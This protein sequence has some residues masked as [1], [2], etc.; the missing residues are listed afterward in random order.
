[1]YGNS[2]PVQSDINHQNSVS[3]EDMTNFDVLSQNYVCQ[4]IN[5]YFSIIS[6]LISVYKVSFQRGNFKDV[7]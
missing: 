2:F 4:D 1:M 5:L 7:I 3:S 6:D